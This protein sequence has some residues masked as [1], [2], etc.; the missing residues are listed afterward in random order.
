[1]KKQFLATSAIIMGLASFAATPAMSAN[2]YKMK[3]TDHDWISVTGHIDSIS[4]ERFTLDFD[5]GV[6]TVEMDGWD[7]YDEAQLLNEGE[8]VTVNGR[9]DNGLYEAKTIEADTVYSHGRRTYFYSNATDEEG[10]YKYYSFYSY[11][12]E[13]PDGTWMSL[14]GKVTDINDRE[15]V[16][17]TLGGDVVV[18]TKTMNFN[19]LDDAGYVQIQEGDRI[20]VSGE[21][22]INLFD[23]NEVNAKNIFTI[24]KY[25]S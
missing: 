19:P 8:R 11:P 20:H 9:I 3:Y 5:G 15:L 1:M 2:P 4:T 7:G 24:E 10:D 17:N 18:D 12:A 21:F 23:K 22:D 14:S 16:L 25:G 6:I 13:I